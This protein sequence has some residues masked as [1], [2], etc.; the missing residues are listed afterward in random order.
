MPMEQFVSA[1]IGPYVLHRLIGRGDRT[2]VYRATSVQETASVAVKIMLRADSPRFEEEAATLHGLRHPHLLP[3]L[4]YGMQREIVYLVT[5]LMKGG[6]LAQRIAGGSIE[7]R[8]LADI[9][10]PI[11]ETLDFLHLHGCLHRDVKPANILFNDAGTVFLADPPLF[12]S[13]LL[14]DMQHRVRVSGPQAGA[15]PYHPPEQQRRE[16][17]TP[18]ADLYGLAV[19]T[20]EMIAT[21]LKL[22]GAHTDLPLALQAVFQRAMHPEPYNRFPNAMLFASQ[23]LSGLGETGHSRDTVIEKPAGRLRI[24]ISYARADE[25]ALHSLVTHLEKRGHI[26]WYD[27]ELKDRGGQK[28][29]DNILKEIRRANLII[30]AVSDALIKSKPCRDELK[31]AF[32]L[33]KNVLPVKIAPADLKLAMPQLAVLEIVDFTEPAGAVHLD[34]SIKNLPRSRPLPSPLPEPPP[35]PLSPLSAL[36]EEIHHADYLDLPRQA[37]LILQCETLLEEGSSREAVIELLKAMRRRRDLTVQHNRKINDLIARF[38]RRRWLLP[39]FGL[40]HP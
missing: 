8:Q 26:V 1:S 19:T 4:D 24:F 31:Y 12:G 37:Y 13:P 16:P 6:S 40:P 2:A 7:Q 30:P 28:W 33:G 27:R 11:A 22:D 23:V 3:V 35:A 14:I 9:L 25:K 20:R 17:L 29:W 32:D 21:A 34:G 38:A 10:L 15:P 39:R 18:A 36:S 5:P